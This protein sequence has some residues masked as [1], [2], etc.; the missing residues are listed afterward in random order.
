MN[1]LNF[2]MP[3]LTPRATT[4][5]DMARK[6]R[7]I[8]TG[9]HVEDTKPP[10]RSLAMSGAVRRKSSEQALIKYSRDQP[11]MTL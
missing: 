1:L 10:K 2:S 4:T 5:A 8:I 7:C 11:P 9:T 3:A 6:T